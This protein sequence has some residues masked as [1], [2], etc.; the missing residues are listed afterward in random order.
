VAAQRVLLDQP[1]FAEAHQVGV[2][3]GGRHVGLAGQVFQR[4][5]PA[6]AGQGLQQL[7]A[8]FHTLDASRRTCLRILLRVDRRVVFFGTH[9]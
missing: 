8:H 6:R 2:G 7:S 1:Q 9:A 5:L 4:H 3:F